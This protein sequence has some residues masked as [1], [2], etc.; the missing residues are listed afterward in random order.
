MEL[1]VFAGTVLMLRRIYP[2]FDAGRI[3]RGLLR[4]HWLEMAMFSFTIWLANLLFYQSAYAGMDISLE[5]DWVRC[6]DKKN[7]TWMGGFDWEC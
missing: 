1:L 3:L 2:E 5:F 4:M 7:S 6:K